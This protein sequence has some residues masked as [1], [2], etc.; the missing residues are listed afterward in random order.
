[1]GISIA[2]GAGDAAIEAGASFIGGD[3]SV[4]PDS[5]SVTVPAKGVGRSFLSQIN[6]GAS[7]S[8]V[9]LCDQPVSLVIVARQIA[10]PSGVGYKMLVRKNWSEIF[11]SN[12]INV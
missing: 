10:L 12:V 1:V 6:A 5:S 2:G 3:V 11:P 9:K 4:S 8:Y 7:R